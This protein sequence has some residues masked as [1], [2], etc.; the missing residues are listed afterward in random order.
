MSNKKRAI[1]SVTND[2]MTDNRVNKTC[3]VLHDLDYEVILVGRKRRSSRPIGKRI[4]KTKRMKLIFERGALFYASFNL[5]LFFYLL[6][7]KADLLV[8]NDLDTLLAN[9]LAHKVKRRSKLVYDTH[10]LFTEVPELTSRPKVRNVWLRI[11][12]MI[13]PKL[14]TIITVNQSIA[15]IYKD[16]YGKTLYVVRNVSPLWTT[17]E[18]QPK[19]SLDIPEK[20]HLLILQ[21]AGINVDR[22]AEELIEAMQSIEANLMIVGDGDVVSLLKTQVQRLNIAHKVFFFGRRP[23]HEM[24]Q[25]T[26]HA[27]L[28]FTLDKP[29]N[30]NYKY[31]LPNKLFDYMHSGTPIISTEIKEVAN[32][33]RKHDIGRIVDPLTPDNLSKVVNELLADAPLLDRL[34]KNCSIA[35]NQENWELESQILKNIYCN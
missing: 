30:L 24:M 17:D 31:S 32:V 10:E 2:L 5:R 9:Y 7:H 35:S 12:R 18:V 6:T 3:M 13:F 22:G 21:G 19:S 34:K 33:I 25:F 11:E 23:Y 14:D 26:K 29:T 4:Y 28:G 15:D 1:V 8:S 16:R 27:D 20:G